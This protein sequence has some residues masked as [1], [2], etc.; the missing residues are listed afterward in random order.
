MHFGKV[1][2][3]DRYSVSPEATLGP[4][5]REKRE[6]AERLLDSYAASDQLASKKERRREFDS[7]W[8][9]NWATVTPTVVGE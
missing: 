5:P 9:C 6:W 3:G 2:V 8:V 4:T 7:S 1:K